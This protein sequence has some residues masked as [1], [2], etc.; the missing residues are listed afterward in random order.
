M[1]SVTLW[2]MYFVICYA[3]MVLGEF[4]PQEFLIVGQ[5]RGDMMVGAFDV[6]L[7]IIGGGKLLPDY[8][9]STPKA[10]LHLVVI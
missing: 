1:I 5:Y 7:I 6:Q 10:M 2:N 4:L 8:Q 9:C 3:K